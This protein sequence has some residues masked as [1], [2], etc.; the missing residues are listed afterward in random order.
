MKT[1]GIDLGRAKT[2]VCVEGQEDFLLR[3][4][5][6]VSYLVGTARFLKAGEAAR[7]QAATS[8]NPVNLLD[9]NL[10][11]VDAYPESVEAMLVHCLDEAAAKLGT[12]AF[13]LV[14]A[15]SGD[16]TDENARRLESL[17]LR[18]GA[19]E[20][21]FVTKPVAAARGSGLLR[22]DA[23]AYILADVGHGSTE[24]A[25]FEGVQMIGSRTLELGG[26][27]FNASIY[28]F[29]KDDLQ[30]M[31]NPTAIENM[32]LQVA[33]LDP[34]AENL[35]IGAEGRDLDT[36]VS[37]KAT[38]TSAQ[39]RDTVE[40]LAHR[41]AGQLRALK[42]PLPVE[43]ADAADNNGIFLAGGG[44][45]LRGF[46]HWLAE[47]LRIPVRHVPDPIGAVAR[48]ALGGGPMRAS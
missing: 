14:I 13:R 46:D 30:M 23:G 24:L 4:P 33:S 27:D 11:Q 2:L 40:Y 25:V 19:T 10:S 1:L 28:Q 26:S 6:V 41:I 32:K 3:E 29:L 9:V 31:F 15:I 34:C 22:A 18:A 37:R 43:V 16:M 45:L 42:G 36:G 7:R 48:G 44:S 8:T 21:R 12:D 17:A 35:A 47:E 39:L 20:V 38:I 5:S